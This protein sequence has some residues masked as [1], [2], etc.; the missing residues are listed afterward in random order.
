MN[1]HKAAKEYLHKVAIQTYTLRAEDLE[2]EQLPSHYFNMGYTMKLIDES[3]SL[4]SLLQNIR[5]GRF[6]DLG[7]L[8]DSDDQAVES[9][10]ECVFD[11]IQDK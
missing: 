3:T 8:Q 1:L 7:Y 6:D 9:F 2:T 11:Y 4:M 10:L 5:M